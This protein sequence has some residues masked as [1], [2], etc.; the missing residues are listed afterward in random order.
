MFTLTVP[1][2]FP[3]S[4]FL[5]YSKQPWGSLSYTFWSSSQSEKMCRR[6]DE[7]PASK[8]FL[9]GWKAVTDSTVLKVSGS[10][11]VCCSWPFSWN[12]CTLRGL[13]MLPTTKQSSR[14]GS[15]TADNLVSQR[16]VCMS[17]LKMKIVCDQ[18]Q[19]PQVS[20][21]RRETTE[22]KSTSSVKQVIVPDGCQQGRF[23]SHFRCVIYPVNRDR[24]RHWAGTEKS[25]SGKNSSN[26][27]NFSKCWV[28]LTLS[29]YRER[30]WELC[31]LYRGR[32][33]RWLCL[34]HGHA[35]GRR[36]CYSS[37]SGTCC[38]KFS[39]SCR[40]DQSIHFVP[41]KRLF[42]KL[43]KIKNQT[44]LLSATTK[45]CLCKGWT[46][47]QRTALE[48]SEWRDSCEFLHGNK[49]QCSTFRKYEPLIYKRVQIVHLYCYSSTP[50]RD[51]KNYSSSSTVLPWGA[52]VD[53]GNISEAVPNHKCRT[54]MWHEVKCSQAIVN[55][56]NLQQC[57]NRLTS[58]G[59][60]GWFEFRL[61][62]HTS[63]LKVNFQPNN[64]NLKTN[65]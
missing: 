49:Y 6:P 1:K 44:Y 20:K 26:C 31:S 53:D 16:P 12:T 18:V 64:T 62:V 37:S 65:I 21:H 43:N 38:R 36:P 58:T 51:T 19:V 40:Q 32:N 61:N 55:V 17:C 13:N 46:W 35:A 4:N 29:G 3:Y 11:K 7:L 27:N 2:L 41:S 50:C 33:T 5:S 45:Y 60:A 25:K 15:H 52:P 30:W 8:A 59:E 9:V 22:Q 28:S 34:K 10:M 39:Q 57:T 24:Q 23:S 48:S 42:W 47:T 56:I 54:V 14:L 63:Y